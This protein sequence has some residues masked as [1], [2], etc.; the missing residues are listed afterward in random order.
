MSKIAIYTSI[1]GKCKKLIEDNIQLKNVDYICFTD[2]NIKS[3]NWK[4]INSIP[5]YEDPDRNEKKFKILP[6]RYL[7]DYNYSIW[8]DASIKVIGDISSLITKH[9]YQI[10]NQSKLC[11]DKN[12]IYK[13]AEL[14]IKTGIENF[15]KDPSKKEFSFEDNPYIIKKQIGRYIQDK[16]PIENGLAINNIILRHHNNKEVIK[17]MEDWWVEIKNWSKIDRLSF[18]Y[19]VWKNNFEYKCLENERDKFLINDRKY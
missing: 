1:F 10:Y 15:N 12:C 4:I 2:E 5:I 16:Y 13:E 18:N 7:K 11:N 3:S 19:I 8:I 14:I 6:H 17:N 9:H